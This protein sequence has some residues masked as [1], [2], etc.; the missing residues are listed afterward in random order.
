ME[1]I[2]SVRLSVRQMEGYTVN[3]DSINH[4]LLS[5]YFIF[6]PYAY[7]FNEKKGKYVA[8]PFR[9]D[10]QVNV[11]VDTIVYSKDSLRS[12]VLVII[13]NHPSKHKDLLSSKDSI[14]FDG[15]AVIGYRFD[16]RKDFYLFP[17][18][19]WS[20]IGNSTY[21]DTRNDLRSFYFKRIRGTISQDCEYP[22]G[23]GDSA[24][25]SLAPVFKKDSLGRYYFETYRDQ[26]K[27]YQYYNYE[28]DPDSYED[29]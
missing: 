4:E 13:E 22:C 28:I 8:S 29:R 14:W 16:K 11:S 6:Y 9:T 26:G 2:E 25:F 23:I 17:I 24:F 18:V 12:V 27:T 19:F 5:G 1:N 3:K 10:T 15:M 7:R 20:M 21:S